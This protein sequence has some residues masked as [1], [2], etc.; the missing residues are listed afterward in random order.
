MNEQSPAAV[1]GVDLNTSE[2][3]VVCIHSSG[4]QLF[5]DKAL[6]L[7]V[8]FAMNVLVDFALVFRKVAINLGHQIDVAK[9]FIGVIRIR[10]VV[11][12]F[13]CTFQVSARSTVWPPRHS[14]E[15]SKKGAGRCVKHGRKT[16]WLVTAGCHDDPPVQ[17][18]PVVVAYQGVERKHFNEISHYLVSVIRKSVSHCGPH[19]LK[20]VK[21]LL[22]S[23]FCIPSTI[24]ASRWDL[25]ISNP[26]YKLSVLLRK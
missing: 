15:H 22:N 26:W 1:F 2:S 18:V 11:D 13:E 12:S 23:R 7:V 10:S 24:S 19:C 20:C 14:P 3:T 5:F 6:C 9:V 16:R 8:K 4:G 21:L 17:R 25:K